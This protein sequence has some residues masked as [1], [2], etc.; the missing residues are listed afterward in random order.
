MSNAKGPSTGAAADQEMRRLTRRSFITGG[1]AALSGLGAWRWLTTAAAEDGVP[2][3][4]RRIL[5]FNQGLAEALGAPHG[6]APTFP[7][8]S[9]KGPARINGLIG[10]ANEV[11][12]A[13]SKV[14]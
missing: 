1:V 10:L 13:G 2:W 8:E 5:R 14:E 12:G 11:Y 4:L 7:A 9:V 3:P 6:L